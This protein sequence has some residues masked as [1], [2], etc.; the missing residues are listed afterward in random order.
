[1]FKKMGVKSLN[2][3][4]MSNDGSGPPP[5]KLEE[6]K[7]FWESVMGVE[8]DYD[9]RHRYFQD[10]ET[11]FSDVEQPPSPKFDQNIWDKVLRRCKSWKAPGKDGVQ[12]F[13]FKTFPEMGKALGQGLWKILK[14]PKE[15]ES[16]LV[17]G[18]TV[19]IPKDGCEGKPQ[20]YR[21]ITCLNV[22][23]KLFT[24][25]VTEI[26]Y[27]HAT[28]VG[29]I[30]QEQRAL[31]R[32]KRGC[33]DALHIDGMAARIAKREKMDLSV[34][35]IDYQKAFDRVPH[36]WILDMLTAIK[37]PRRIVRCLAHI[38]PMWSTTFSVGRRERAQM[39]DI[40]YKRGIFQGD[41]LSPLLFCL[42]LSPISHRLR[43]TKGFVASGMPGPLTHLFFVD[44]LK[45]YASSREN[46]NKVL[47]VVQRGSKAVGMALGLNKCG[48]A[49][50]TVGRVCQAGESELKGTGAIGEITYSTLYKYLGVEQVFQP[51]HKTVRNRLKVKFLKRLRTIWSSSL[52][53]KNKVMAMNTW[54]IAVFR[55][56]MTVIW[57]PRSELKRIDGAARK[58][59]TQEN[60]H[61]RG[62]ATERL[63]LRRDN[64]GRGVMN[65]TLIWEREQVS[66]IRYLQ[67]SVDPWLQAVL[68]HLI[69]ES[70]FCST[71][72]VAACRHIL[73]RYEIPMPRTTLE[74]NTLGDKLGKAQTK[75]LEM[76]LG[77]KT[78]H[79]THRR[80]LELEGISKGDSHLWLCDGR[81][82]AATEA[83]V[84]AAQDG[85]MAT[86]RYVK[87]VWSMDMSAHCRKCGKVEETIGNILSACDE[88][89]WGSYKARHD[90]VM[91]ALIRAVARKW[92][93]LAELK[94]AAPAVY[95]TPHGIIWVD[96]V[97][98]TDKVID[99][100][101]PDIVIFNKT[102]TEA[103]IIDIACA[104]EPLLLD[105]EAQKVAK[106]LEL[107]ADLG[108]RERRWHIRTMAVVVGT[109][110][111]IGTPRHQLAQ[112]DLWNPSEITGVIKELQY[113][114]IKAGA[115][116]LRRHFAIQN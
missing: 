84:I 38:I 28:E 73:K 27:E 44:D 115:Q 47:K 40:Q 13:W 97:I 93:C 90:T 55:Y 22:M 35:W 17:E 41:S 30:P 77:E 31:A 69:S 62:A 59:M 12:G 24:A 98:P 29:A 43:R 2:N 82:K 15:I 37:T 52:S 114:T 95:D 78:I 92:G 79:G 85:T 60:G 68:S 45:V 54:A 48:V 57:W 107:A 32:G 70:E 80:T 16:W 5:A 91:A 58:V 49:H 42:A 65:V 36:Q 102:T 103:W 83:L 71:N 110:G 105:R 101:R 25:I 50:M 104:W 64:G 8:G 66:M 76:A 26:L 96:I 53:A 112:L 34:A 11:Q 4:A 113:Q 88:Y 100:R 21:P 7:A 111:T 67:Q 72:T 99:A 14:H 18:R 86:N 56:Y 94:G 61:H 81:V 39:F 9:P 87:Q 19:L 74:L 63:Y 33:L 106:Y 51:N 75:E 89:K 46:L 23:Y 1:M 116:L 10:W 6:F 108:R 3:P 20:Q 109:L